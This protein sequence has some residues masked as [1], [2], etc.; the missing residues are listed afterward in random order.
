MLN[1]LAENYTN[2]IPF[3]VIQGG[4]KQ[5][6]NRTNRE[7]AESTEVYAFRNKNEISAMIDVFDK[8]IENADNETNRWIASRNKLLFIIGIN[9]GIRASDLRTLQWNF[10]FDMKNDEM[11]FKDFYSL[12]PMKQRKYKKFVKLYFNN[13]VKT[14]INNYIKEYPV[15]DLNEYLFSSRKGNEPISVSSLWRIIKDTA[16]EAGI[17][18]NIG[19]HSLRKTWGYFCWHEAEDKNKAII[20]LQKCFNHDSSLTTMKYIGLLDDEISDMYNS[21]N[22]G[23]EF[24]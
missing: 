4:K 22:L 2:V 23:I 11:I 16:K 18:Q 9:I 3:E 13:A 17:N 14:A 12:Q 8:H 20:I 24:I 1:A 7:V 10:F 19:S 15:D 21:I 5:K 6:P